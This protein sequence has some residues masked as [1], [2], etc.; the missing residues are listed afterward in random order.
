[1]SSSIVS[2]E[3]FIQFT[4][5]TPDDSDV[6]IDIYI[7]SATDIINAYLGFNTTDLS[8][9]NTFYNVEKEEVDIPDI[10]KL[11]CLE[12]AS[13]MQLEENQNIGVNSSN[14]ESG[15]SRTFL[16]IVDYT[17][18]LNK[19]ACYRQIKAV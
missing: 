8:S 19:L 9:D 2:K 10:V 7:G 1:M 13:L 14:F 16:N 18:Y 17:K 5:I 11:V 6:L 4:G 15:G 3:Q 12:I